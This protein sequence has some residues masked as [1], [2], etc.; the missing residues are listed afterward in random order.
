M[1]GNII[2]GLVMLNF[3]RK[4]ALNQILRDYLIGFTLFI[5]IFAVAGMDAGSAKSAQMTT[6]ETYFERTDAPTVDKLAPQHNLAKFIAQS[7]TPE[8]GVEYRSKYRNENEA[9]TK[10]GNLDNASTYREQQITGTDMNAIQALQI[11]SSD[12]LYLA[13]IAMLFASMFTITIG[14]WRNVR[15]EYASPRR[16]GWRR[17]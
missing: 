2:P 6:G 3:K 4:K 13:F 5:T 17:D 12:A 14:F 7:L 10:N 1:Q 9:A 11:F 8:Y 15:R 16:T